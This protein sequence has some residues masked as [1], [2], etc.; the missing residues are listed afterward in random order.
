MKFLRTIRNED[1]GLTPALSNPTFH[2]RHSVRAILSDHEGCIALMHVTKLH[3]HKLP[4]GGIEE[5]EDAAE[6]LVREVL[7]ETGC[8]LRITGLVGRV[9]EEKILNGQYRAEK[10]LSDCYVA[11]LE[12]EKGEPSFTVEERARAFVPLWVPLDEAL[13]LL[14][15]DNPDDVQGKFIRLRELTFLQ[16]Y[17]LNVR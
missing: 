6:A 11:V 4:G 13:R 3:Y 9:A 1:V 7:E 15:S 2:Q 12:G 14:T 16:T 17:A 10:Q 5:G 8:H